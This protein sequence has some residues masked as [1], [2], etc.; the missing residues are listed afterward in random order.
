MSMKTKKRFAV[1]DRVRL[2]GDFLRSTGQIAGGEGQSKWV[3]VSCDCR[4]CE[5]KRFV[6]TDEPHYDVEGRQRHIAAA[7]LEKLRQRR[8]A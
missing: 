5:S 4:M 7:N 6:A 8:K 3:V 1:G 2:T